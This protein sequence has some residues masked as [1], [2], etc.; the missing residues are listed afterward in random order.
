MTGQTRPAASAGI[1]HITAIAKDPRR[2]LA[3]YREVLGLRL[4]KKT[5]NFDDPGTYHLYYGDEIGHPGTILT[6]FPWP[7][8]A[9]GRNGTGQAVETTFAI[10]QA[11]LSFWIG[12]LVEKG[13]PHDAPETRFGETVVGF[14][15]P[16]GMRLELVAV[17]GMDTLPG[18]AADGVPT[19]H[20][21][22]GF[23]G[24]TIWV[25]D[26]EPTAK[27]LEGA[28]GYRRATTEAGRTRFV[29][30]A[31]I[32]N[33]VDLRVTAGFPKGRLGV[34]TIHHVAF[35][36]ASDEAQAS[37]TARLRGDGLHVTEQMDRNYFRSVYFREP[38]G[39]LFEIA[40]DDPGFAVDEPPASLGSALML[41]RQYEAH[42][43]QIE[44]ALPALG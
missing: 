5:V 23:R 27:V 38:A 13:V 31:A 20:A 8:V 25:E 35:R 42:R 24:V 3:F 28:F 12:R 10:P 4:V 7:H 21:I 30:Q 19:E 6:F 39:T 11:S 43:A 32:G 29:S 44:A 2:N 41:P 37:M 1:H 9:S 16:D 34:G 40:T 33:V 18:Y 15:D 36:A 14:R 26:I 22:R 17:A